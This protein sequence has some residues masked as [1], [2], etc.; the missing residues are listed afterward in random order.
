MIIKSKTRKDAKCYSQLVDYVFKEDVDELDERSFTYLFGFD[1]EVMPD[2]IEKIKEVFLE[3]G[4]PI[5]NKE[6]RVKLYHEI[7]SFHE[8]DS[9]HLNREILLDIAQKYIGLRCFNAPAL[10]RPHFD[11]EHLHLHILYAGNEQ[12]ST[13]STRISKEQF[14]QIQQKMEEYQRDIYKQLVNSQVD[15][16][17]QGNQAKEQ[18]NEPQKYRRDRNRSQDREVQMQR[19]GHQSE[20]RQRLE[21]AVSPVIQQASSLIELEQGLRSLGY[22]T[23]TYHQRLNGIMFDNRKYR[24]TTLAKKDVQLKE[25]LQKLNKAYSE[26]RKEQQMKAHLLRSMEQN[27]QK[28]NQQQNQNQQEHEL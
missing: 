16:F 3:N 6:K 17:I 8:G 21:V 5:L 13:K 25:K 18:I 22:E 15:R 1:L 12:E 23:Y 7:I 20:I 10:A 19:R 26:Q 27:Q 4:K 2:D 28:K 14:G 24:L 9:K 11:K